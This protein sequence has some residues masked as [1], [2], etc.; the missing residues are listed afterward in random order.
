MA[1]LDEVEAA[2]QE[3]ARAIEAAAVAAEPAECR[4]ISV[5]RIL[6][7]IDLAEPPDV[8]TLEEISRSDSNGLR[9]RWA[10][11]MLSAASLP[12]TVGFEVQ[13]LCIEPG[14]VMIFWPGEVVADYALWFKS[15][16]VPDGP[17]LLAGAYANGTV[18]YVP[19]RE[20]YPL[21]GYEVNGSHF[22]YSLPAAYSPSVEDQLREISVRLMQGRC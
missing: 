4:R 14:A 15:L 20:I 5:D 3:L 22:Y 8:G 19:S 13:L 6:E 18:G 1:E 2:G 11:R 21:G 17:R 10:D 7:E 9:Q 16:E 12:R